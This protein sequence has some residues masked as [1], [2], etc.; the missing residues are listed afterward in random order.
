MMNRKLFFTSVFIFLISVSEKSSAQ[1]LI[2]NGNLDSVYHKD[3]HFTTCTYN[4]LKGNWTYVGTT[5]TYYKRDSINLNVIVLLNFLPTLPVNRRSFLET[6]LNSPLCENDT[7]HLSFSI[8]ANPYLVI[9]RIGAYFSDSLITIDSVESVTPQVQTPNHVFY[10]APGFT[11]VYLTYIAK[12][13]EQYLTIGNF[14][15]KNKSHYKVFPKNKNGEPGE[16]FIDDISLEH[17][18]RES[19][20]VFRK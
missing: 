2:E 18:C 13:G 17:S 5:M 6:K 4:D 3:A 11:K 9:D 1:N 14:I 10:T 16:Y 15:P 19:E 8:K 20:S 12:G 7:C